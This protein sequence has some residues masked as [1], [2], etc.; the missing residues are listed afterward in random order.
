MVP[1]SLDPWHIITNLDLA[2]FSLNP[3]RA[4]ILSQLQYRNVRFA[5]PTKPAHHPVAPY[6][7]REV[8]MKNVTYLDDGREFM[9]GQEPRY[10]Y[11]EITVEGF[12]R[13][14]FG[15]RNDIKV[16]VRVIEDGILGMD[17]EPLEPE[18]QLP[19]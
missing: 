17:I 7:L 14:D 15:D 16:E 3:V 1:N 12:D 6:S 4:D 19:P 13:L 9:V 2:S 11:E 18:D 5:D 10:Q 8:Q